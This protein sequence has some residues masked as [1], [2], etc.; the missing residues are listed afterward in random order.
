MQPILTPHYPV[1]FNDECYTHLQDILQP[2]SY[3]R[4]FL[5]ADSNSYN[6]CLPAF[7]AD[8]VTEIPFEIIE[9]EPGEVNKTIETCVEIWHTLTELGADRKSLVINLGGGVVTD[10]GGFAASLF[11]RGVDFINVPTTL[12]AM[13]DASIGGKT[14][15]DLGSLK[16]QVGLVSNPIAVLIDTRFLETLPA[17]QMRSG[18]AEMLKHGLIADRAYW[19]KFTVLNDLDVNDLDGLIRES[20]VIKNDIVIEDPNEKGIRK[21]LNFGHT[22]GHAIESYFLEDTNKTTLLHGEAIAIGMVLETYLTKEKGFITISEYHEIRNTINSIFPKTIFTD[23]DIESIYGLLVHDK[24]NEFG[25]VL[26]VLLN[27]IGNVKINEEVE[28]MLI[29]KAFGDYSN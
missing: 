23:T 12:L 2:G 16:N 24:K 11:K 29:F 1:Y 26:F 7:M 28:K 3:S 22:L 14:G 19:N 17:Q 4:I 10:M 8:V 9:T 13:V 21:A 5:I 15:V 25:I 20:V 18:L 27:G 6:F